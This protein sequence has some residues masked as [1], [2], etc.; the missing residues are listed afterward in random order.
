[1]RRIP[2]HLAC[3]VRFNRL[4]GCPIRMLAG[5]SKGVRAT[6]WVRIAVE[7]PFPPP[8]TPELGFEDPNPVPVEF[9]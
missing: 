9:P 1:M 5:G 6:I 4:A 7:I 3:K 8:N 2:E